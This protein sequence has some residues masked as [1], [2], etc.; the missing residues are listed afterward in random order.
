[1]LD[2]VIV[3]WN[4]GVQLR[5]CLESILSHDD[6]F[7]SRVVVVDNG[8]TDGS[9]DN[10]D[11]F[12]G[13][14]IIPA[15]ENLG[16]S[17]AC[18]LGAKESSAPFLLF[19]N[20]DAR[21]QSGSIS[22]P[23][24]FL[25][26]PENRRVGIC[27]IQLFDEEGTIS[28]SC[29]RFPTLLRFSASAVGLDKLQRYKKTGVIMSDWDHESSGFVN[30]VIGAFY[31]VR[32]CVFEELGGFDDRFFVYM[33]DVD[34][35]SRALAAGWKCFYL[36]EARAFHAGGGSSRQIK[37]KRLFYS[38][39]SRLLYAFKH[40]PRW[41]AWVLVLL[42]ALVEP[43][44]RVIWCGIHGDRDGISQTVSAYLMLWRSVGKTTRDLMD[45]ET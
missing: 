27:G 33:E 19:L 44:T 26:S 7:I 17:R 35:S 37:A 41:Q 11:G 28:R 21:V 18:N 13:V 15:F 30:H 5:Q 3:N 12:P 39:R 24:T 20:P 8:S 32:R 29:A 31:F 22:L 6:Q 23:L 4:S 10:L 45:Y 9:A 14:S 25:Q 38:L 36:A 16:F 1:M 43:L 40:F 2:V 34:F 42:T